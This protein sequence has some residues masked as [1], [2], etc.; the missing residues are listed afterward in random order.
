MHTY[1]IHTYIRLIHKSVMKTVGCGRSHKYAHANIR[2]KIPKTFYKNI[3]N[4][5][6][7]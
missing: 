6:Y 4:N 3:I 7:T 2:C 5:L 1:I